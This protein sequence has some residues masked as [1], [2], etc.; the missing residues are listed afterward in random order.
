MHSSNNQQQIPH[1]IELDSQILV[2]RYSG[3]KLWRIKINR[4]SRI[5]K[6]KENKGQVGLQFR[7]KWMLTLCIL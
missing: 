5:N 4:I 2:S 6:I 3:L 7:I 1:H